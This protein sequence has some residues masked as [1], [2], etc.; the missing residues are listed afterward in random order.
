M[1]GDFEVAAGDGV[2]LQVTGLSKTIRAL[3]QAGADA[4]DMRNLMHSIGLLVVDAANPPVVSGALAGTVRA[5]RGKTKAVVRAGGALAPYAGVIHHGWPARGIP[6][7]QFLTHALQRQ[8]AS[9]LQALDA[10]LSDLLRKNNL[11]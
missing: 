9:A 10:G 5:G 11:K 4:E 1:A 8:Q 7:N 2:R 3:S 6:E